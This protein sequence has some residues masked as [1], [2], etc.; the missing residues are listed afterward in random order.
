[1]KHERRTADVRRALVNAPDILSAAR[2]LREAV[3]A[4]PGV[5]ADPDTVADIMDY[6]DAYM[7]RKE[8][9][10]GQVSGV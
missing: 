9:L 4:L 5:S 6:V 7:Y 8:Q 3:S 10:D 1:M 2:T